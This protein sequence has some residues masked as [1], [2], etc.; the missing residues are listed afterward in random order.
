MGLELSY[1]ILLYLL[2]NH[3]IWRASMT[4]FPKFRAISDQSKNH[5]NWYWLH[6]RTAPSVIADRLVHNHNHIHNESWLIMLQRHLHVNVIV[7]R[8]QYNERIDGIRFTMCEINALFINRSGFVL[9]PAAGRI[10]TTQQ[11]T[12]T[13]SF[14]VR[15][16]LL[17]L[18]ITFPFIQQVIVILFILFYV[19]SKYDVQI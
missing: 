10:E 3:P 16:T 17:S 18:Q 14:Y 1:S 4:Y 7:N 15:Y 8:T 19:I 9:S 13:I 12:H 6:R 2:L 11:W 5:A